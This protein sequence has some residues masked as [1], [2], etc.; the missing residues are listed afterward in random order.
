MKQYLILGMAVCLATGIF[1]QNDTYKHTFHGGA[2]LTGIGF[3]LNLADD[4]NL[5]DATF[6]IESED[7]T[8]ASGR[9]MGNATP[10]FQI[11]YDYGVAKWFS[12]GIGASYQRLGFDFTDFTY[13]D[14]NGQV[15]DI[16]DLNINANRLN[17]TLRPLFHYGNS[18]KIDM[19]SGFRVGITNWRLGF[20]TSNPNL[21][22]DLKDSPFFG[23]VPTAQLIPFALRAYLSENFGLSFELGIGAPHAI[24]LGVNYCL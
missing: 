3:I 11:A 1:A 4:I 19:Y 10:A 22:E 20:D 16:G 18:D 9:F 17:L 12:I 6:E 14:E 23:I 13:T 5:D 7:I 15:N 8:D 2:G 24:A 21:E